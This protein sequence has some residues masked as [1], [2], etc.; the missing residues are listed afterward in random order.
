MIIYT[1]IFSN[2][3]TLKEPGIITPGW[4]YVCFTDQS[5]RSKVW[6][7]VQTPIID[8]PQKT[9]RRLKILFHNYLQD[10]VSIYIDASFI[11][12]C[13]LNQWMLTHFKEPITVVK[14]PI[15]D[16]VYEEAETVVRNKRKGIEGISQQIESYRQ[17]VPPHNGLIQSGLLMRSKTPE[18]ISLM[19]DW[20]KEVDKHS[21]RDQI[22]FSK[23][24]LNKQINS[25]TWDYRSAKE[26]LYK[27]HCTTRRF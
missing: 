1:S 16:C 18:I 21:L 24:S 7:V 20:W 27:G 2:Y 3:D 4:R 22:A 11:I 17:E 12:N 26:F 14:H 15:R 25:I 10:E 9:A 5:L 19:E 13:N 6:E 23:I 8:T